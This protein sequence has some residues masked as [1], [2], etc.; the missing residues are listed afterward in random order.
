MTAAERRVIGQVSNP[1]KVPLMGIDIR[2]VTFGGAIGLL[3]IAAFAIDLLLPAGVAAGTL[4]VAVVLLGAWLPWRSSLL[5]L[6]I[7]A[8]AL[9]GLGYLLDS[10]GEATRA[11][12]PV[13]NRGLTVFAIWI[14]A[15]LTFW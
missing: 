12:I 8:T 3:T 14:A 6:A 4:Y 1:G 7:V 15:A 10:A 2:T 5:V 11:W 9:T 13:A